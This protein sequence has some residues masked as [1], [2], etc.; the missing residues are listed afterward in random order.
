MSD[1]KRQAADA[2]LSLLP[3]AGIIGL[4]SGSTAR[5]FIEGVARLVGEGRDL[6]GVANAARV[7]V[8]SMKRL[9]N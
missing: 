8:R 1:A 2:A 3:E 6:R 9:L 5:L 4:G 7:S